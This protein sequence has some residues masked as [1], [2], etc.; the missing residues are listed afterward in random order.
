ML[1]AARS[2]AP[3]WE[4][5]HSIQKS[6]DRSGHRSG[7][8]FI[9]R[10]FTAIRSSNSEE[11]TSSRHGSFLQLP[12]RQCIAEQTLRAMRRHGKGKKSRLL[13][14]IAHADGK[15]QRSR[16]LREKCSVKRLLCQHR[17][18]HDPE[19]PDRRAAQH[20]PPRRVGKNCIRYKRVETAPDTGVVSISYVE[21]LLRSD[22]QIRRARPL[23][24][25]RGM[26]RLV[27]AAADTAAAQAAPPERRSVWTSHVCGTK[28][29]ARASPARNGAA[30]SAGAS[31]AAHGH[32]FSHTWSR[33]QQANHTP[34]SANP[35]IRHSRTVIFSS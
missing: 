3:R 30:A 11:G 33:A 29:D 20:G 8:D 32:F 23:R 27:I 5:L 7:L 15:Y 34:Q 18:R 13:V 25:F 21:Y 26:H 17:L 35:A 28:P 12:P 16:Q 4:E 6:R 14:G 31:C 2:A 19:A 10:I 1:P 22:P 9:R 24:R